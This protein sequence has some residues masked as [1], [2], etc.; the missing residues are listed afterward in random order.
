MIIITFLIY[1]DIYLLF[2]SLIDILD[3]YPKKLAEFGYVLQLN[4]I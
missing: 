3:V 1:G 4:I 2:S